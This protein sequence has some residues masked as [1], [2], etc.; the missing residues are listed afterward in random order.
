MIQKGIKK[1][2]DLFQTDITDWET[3]TA[4]QRCSKFYETPWDISALDAFFKNVAAR[5]P[6]A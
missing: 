4:L 2:W 6:T 5:C 3:E 1:Q